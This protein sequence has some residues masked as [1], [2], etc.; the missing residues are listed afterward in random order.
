[1][2]RVGLKRAA[3]G[4]SDGVILRAEVCGNGDRRIRLTDESGIELVNH[5]RWYV[6]AGVENAPDIYDLIAD[7]VEHQMRESSQRSD[8]EARNLELVGEPQA[9]RLRRST[10]L[11]DGSFD[12]V[13][14]TQGDISVRLGEV[15]VDGP[16]DVVSSTLAKSD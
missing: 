7:D 1:M 5:R 4:A 12:G 14:K 3:D 13:D 6:S 9:A 16:V 10:D 2:P 15:V 8:S 11:A